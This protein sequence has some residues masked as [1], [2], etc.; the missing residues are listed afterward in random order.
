MIDF[1]CDYRGE[2]LP[3][4]LDNEISHIVSKL[5]AHSYK[6]TKFS[7]YRTLTEFMYCIRKKNINISAIGEKKNRA[8]LLAEFSQ[9]EQNNFFFNLNFC[10]QVG[11]KFPKIKALSYPGNEEKTIKFSKKDNKFYMVDYW[12]TKTF[13]E[14]KIKAYSKYFSRNP[15]SVDDIKIICLIS[16]EF[17]TDG[18]KKIIEGLSLQNISFYLTNQEKLTEQNLI[19]MFSEDCFESVIVRFGKVIGLEPELNLAF[20]KILTKFLNKLTIGKK[21][22]TSWH[23]IKN[24]QYQELF[25]TISDKINE[26]K[27]LYSFKKII[28]NF[29]YK[30]TAKNSLEINH[31]CRLLLKWSNLRKFLPI[32]KSLKNYFS[33]II[34]LKSIDFDIK[35]INKG[36]CERGTK[37]N[38]CLEELTEDDNQYLCIE[39]EPKH[40]HCEKCH[41]KKYEGEDLEQFAHPHCLYLITPE[42]TK[43]DELK[44]GKN[45]YSSRCFRQGIFRRFHK[46]ISC[47]NK[48]N[49]L[50]E[51]TGKVEGTRYKCAHCGNYDFCEMCMKK[52]LEGGSDAM[53]KTAKLGGHKIWHVFIVIENSFH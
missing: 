32:A 37:C 40:Y 41:Q 33:Q 17:F 35:S 3:E 51:C 27:S 25:A 20:S 6:F 48:T 53:I 9:Y 34:P 52:W 15:K 1:F 43:F 47:D 28:P 44:F 4:S 39:C 11:Q 18:V 7:A 22:K 31:K 10:T 8:S 38:L 42:S 16:E 13:A 2:I 26:L 36:V 21:S 50:K 29:E 24:N 46:L 12:R 49:P 45:Q 30:V 14:R 5:E 19:K 23:C